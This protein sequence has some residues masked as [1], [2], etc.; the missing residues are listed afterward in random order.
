MDADFDYC[1]F[2][3]TS[4]ESLDWE[5]STGWLTLPWKLCG[6]TLQLLWGSRCWEALLQNILIV[7]ENAS[8]DSID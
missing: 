2:S 8:K 6:N 4:P 5:A 1:E 7:D 3:P